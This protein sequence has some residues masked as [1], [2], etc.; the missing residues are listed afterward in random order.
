GPHAVVLLHGLLGSARN[1][2]TLARGLAS[3]DPGLSVFALDLPG[4]G[5]SPPLAPGA[6]LAAM[7]RDVLATARALAPGAPV[8]L[9]GHSLGGRVA[10]AA[11]RLEPAA[12]AHVAL[13]DITPS[14]RV[15]SGDMA[16][17][18]AALVS[19]PERGTREAFREHFRTV[20]LSPELTEWL[21]M[22]LE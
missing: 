12:L 21:L 1:L 11:G 2:G 19:A 8:A 3:A 15:V 4:H 17:A 7:A 14:P 16:A 5:A 9:M 13:L 20:G 22:N 10:L 6:D 18:M